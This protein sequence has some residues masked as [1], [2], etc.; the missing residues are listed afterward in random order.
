M[1][2]EQPFQ[3]LPANYRVPVL[4]AA[5]AF[6]VDQHEDERTEIARQ[7]DELGEIVGRAN[8]SGSAADIG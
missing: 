3:I 5:T 4:T 6:R 7:D 8:V 1:T 2:V